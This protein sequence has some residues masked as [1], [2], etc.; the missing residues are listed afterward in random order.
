MWLHAAL[1]DDH[2]FITSFEKLSTVTPGGNAEIF[3]G[4]LLGAGK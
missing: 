2:G 4:V 3:V 1:V